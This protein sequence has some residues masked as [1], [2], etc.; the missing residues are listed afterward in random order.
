MPSLPELEV[1]K[2]E[3]VGSLIGPTVAAVD[4]LD[5][6]VVRLD[7]EQLRAQ[8]VGRPFTA[9]HR[10]GKWLYL[11]FGATEQLIFHL[12]LTGKL[13]IQ[14][15]DDKL[16][17]Y[18][19]F[20]IDLDNRTRLVMADQ[21]HLGRIYLRRFEELKAEKML[22]PD[23]LDVTEDYFVNTLSRKRRGARDVLMD[24]KIIAGIGGKYADEILWQAKLHPNTK[25]DRLPREKL[26][27]LF[28]VMQTVTRI[29]IELDADVE[30][31]PGDWLIP[32]R[33][34][35][36]TCPRCGSPLTT[37]KLGGSETFYCPTDQPAPNP[38]RS[39]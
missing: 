20:T 29:A 34:T 5:W 36:K 3:F 39:G 33:R 6:R 21:R 24:Q 38:S 9:V 11:D 30:R 2:Q 32:H 35:D 25:L 37:R 16:P 14:A 1:Y 15:P 8:L 31:F 17:R 7:I 4:A 23:Q 22:G 10:Y 26:S 13:K 18:A 28:H 27:E 12:G 19:C